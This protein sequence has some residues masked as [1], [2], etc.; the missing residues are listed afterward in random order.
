MGV[1]QLE[2]TL[3]PTRS[4]T[5][6]YMT[7]PVLNPIA[8]GLE[9]DEF[10]LVKTFA[11]ISRIVDTLIAPLR[12]MLRTIELLQS[13]RLPMVITPIFCLLLNVLV[14]CLRCT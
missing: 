14:L 12:G 7:A 2:L 9:V 3:N 6:T 8:T 10:S 5:Y 11:Q 4:L 1:V 13:W